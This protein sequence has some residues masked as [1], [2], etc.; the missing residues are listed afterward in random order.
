MNVPAPGEAC[1]F[2]LE[3]GQQ[4]M[5][6]FKPLKRIRS[7]DSVEHLLLG[8]RASSRSQSKASLSS[9]SSSSSEGDPQL[10]SLTSS[11]CNRAIS[12][13]NCW[14]PPSGH[15]GTVEQH[16]CPDAP[17]KL[18]RLSTYSERKTQLQRLFQPLNLSKVRLFVHRVRA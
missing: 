1:G 6:R 14:T 11:P 7:D 12:D 5:S 2:A 18:R 13:E 16:V 4:D 9:H 17:R 10:R 15:T 8:T 3:D